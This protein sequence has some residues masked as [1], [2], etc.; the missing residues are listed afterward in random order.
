MILMVI[1]I[2]IVKLNVMIRRVGGISF[3][4]DVPAG[5]TPIGNPRSADCRLG[6]PRFEGLDR[7]PICRHSYESSIAEWKVLMSDVGTSGPWIPNATTTGIPG[8]SWRSLTVATPWV[9]EDSA[10]VSSTTLPPP[11]E[12]ASSTEEVAA[13]GR[14]TGSIVAAAVIG[15]TAMLLPILSAA[16][17]VTPPPASTQTITMETPP[18][19]TKT[20]SVAPDWHPRLL[21]DLAPTTTGAGGYLFSEG[22]ASRFFSL[23]SAVVGEAPDAGQIGALQQWPDLREWPSLEAANPPEKLRQQA[24]TYPTPPTHRTDYTANR[25][26]Y[27]ALISNAEFVDKTAMSAADIQTYLESVKSYLAGFTENGRTAA[28][29]IAESSVAHQINP[30]IIL[31]TMEKETNLV[32]RAGQP[33]RWRLRSAMGFAYNDSGSSAGRR[34]TFTYQVEQGARLLRELYN[35]GT[36]MAFPASKKVDY[37]R[38]TIKVNNAA[39]WALMRY[40]PHTRDTKLRQIGGGNHA[41][42]VILERMYGENREGLGDRKLA[43]G[44]SAH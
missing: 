27:S 2:M 35:E 30:R 26:N 39:T 43:D 24:R 28:E 31:T 41:F 37:G 1:L 7:D 19:S 5:L 14:T 6:K 16:I 32:S 12:T 13:Q 11:P 25:V 34:S 18:A 3:K 29:I 40:T 44:A 8:G 22:T 42:R 38:R 23:P 15:V 17:S 20:P 10:T 36:A 21:S 4:G 33:E 9:I